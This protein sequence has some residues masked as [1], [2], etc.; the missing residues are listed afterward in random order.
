MTVKRSVSLPDD[1]AAW[2]DKQDNVS[3]AVTAAIRAQMKTNTIEEVM[4]QAGIQLTE[5]GRRK[6]R[7]R[8]AKP[9][10]PEALAEG[11]RMSEAAR[12][13]RLDEYLANRKAT[14]GE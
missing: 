10:P 11:R 1:V 8:L 6:W 5:E 9:I 13:G 7:E 2:L 12:T 14:S 4:A 3:A